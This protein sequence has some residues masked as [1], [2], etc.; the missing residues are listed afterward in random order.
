MVSYLTKR[1]KE[2]LDLIRDF[3]LRNGFAPSLDEIR[4]GLNLSS[5]S[6]VHEH[7]TKLTTKGYLA[8]HPN[9]AR[10]FQLKQPGETVDLPIATLNGIND[11]SKNI[12]LG[13][14][15]LASVVHAD[16][17][18]IA[19][20]V[21]GNYLI[22]AGVYDGDY[23]VVVPGNG[24]LDGDIMVGLIDGTKP[25]MG[26]LYHFGSKAIIKPIT[27]D[28]DSQVVD[29]DNLVVVGRVKAVIRKF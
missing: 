23:I 9:K 28:R 8:R 5:V 25:V 15:D 6:T 26:R 21:Q 13:R 12:N 19:A 7:I 16:K 1:E 17:G 22:Q 3:S 20:L 18:S 24:L 10:S 2:V 29:A 14:L 11:H 27:G 4:I